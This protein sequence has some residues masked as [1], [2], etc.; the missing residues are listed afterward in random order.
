V[1]VKVIVTDINRANDLGFP[2]ERRLESARGTSAALDHAHRQ[3]GLFLAA[4]AGEK[5]IDDMND[6]DH[7]N[8][9]NNN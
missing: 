1:L 3:P 9:L 2:A 7:S 5:L 8:L 6:L 4:E